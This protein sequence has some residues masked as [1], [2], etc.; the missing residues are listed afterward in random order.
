MKWRRYNQLSINKRL[1]MIPFVAIMP[2]IVLVC[3]LVWTVSSATAAYAG[4]N[5]NVERAN[6]YVRDFKE[7][8]DYTMYLSVI[9]NKSINELD[10]GKTTI[11]GIVT[12][13]PY[14]YI[15]ELKTVCD[16]LSESATVDI[17]R[18][19]IKRL[20]N[21]L[22]SLK[23]NVAELEH[24]IKNNELYDANMKYLDDNIYELTALIQSGI[25]N[26]IYIETTNFEEVKEA[27]DKNN[28]RTILLCM[29]TAMVVT[30]L[31]IC[32]SAQ[33]TKSIIVPIRKLCKMTSKVAEG[34]FTAK[35]KVNTKDEIAVLAHNFN[36]MTKEIG[37]LVDDMQHNHETQRILESKLLQAQ[38]NP[39]FLYN[40][41]DTVVW[42]AEAKQNDQVVA[43][44]TYLSEFFRTTLS[45]GQDIITIYDEKRHIES[46]LK[47]Q[48]FRYQDVLEYSIDIEEKLYEVKIP[49]LLLQ[50]LVE[51]ALVHGI[52]NKRGKGHL[53]VRGYFQENDVI[54]EVEDDGKGMNKEELEALIHG[55]DHDSGADRQSGFGVA[56]VN[57]RIHVYYGEQYGISYESHPGEGTLVRIQ[58]AD[59][60]SEDPVIQ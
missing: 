49:K 39:H 50:P 41:L 5:K 55:M 30:A 13:N 60:V 27:L 29:I 18:N 19:Q 22:K 26:Y 11:N 45:K 58:V 53:S 37:H 7:R 33:A 43:I 44:V 51:N 34:D 56:N 23:K 17:N 8:I 38:I 57:Q 35:T 4:I 52:R 16:E 12:V 24:N 48:Q 2:M 28:E 10:I 3:Y 32:L 54:F 46:Y 47:I 6:Q 42:L 14:D 40:T 9:R 20:K 25:Q 36:D 59:H 21:S 15:E 31:S 1:I